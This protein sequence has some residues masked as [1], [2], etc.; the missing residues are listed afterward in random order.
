[1]AKEII[2]SAAPELQPALLFAPAPKAAKR[3]VEFFT[4]QMNNDHTRKAYLNATRRFAAWCDT[5]GI[6]QLADVQPFHVAAFIKELQGEFTA[7]T[8]KQ[9]LAMLR[10]W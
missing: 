6:G 3:V 1:M 10:T 9:H 4:S 5:H 7:P 8:V 2:L